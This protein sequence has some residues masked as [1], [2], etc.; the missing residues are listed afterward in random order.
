METGILPTSA[1]EKRLELDSY[2]GNVSLR[3]L[4]RIG[5]YSSQLARQ[6]REDFADY[7]V[8]NEGHLP[9]QLQSIS[10][11]GHNVPE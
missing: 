6:I 10:E 3:P 1:A 5:G 7:F 11:S 4:T 2:T 8:S 9:W